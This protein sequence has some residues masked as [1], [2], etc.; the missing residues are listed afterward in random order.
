MGRHQTA[1]VATIAAGWTCAQC[2]AKNAGTKFCGNCGNKAPSATHWACGRCK[3]T[4]NLSAMRFCGACGAA[5]QAPSGGVAGT[6]T[7]AVAKAA[8]DA[9]A[10]AMANDDDKYADDEEAARGMD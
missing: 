8:A 2:Q 1:A 7:D 5:Y 3:F 6:Q 4:D 9:A 10:A